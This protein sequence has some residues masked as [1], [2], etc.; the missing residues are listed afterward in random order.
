R[1][2]SM[3]QNHGPWNMLRP[4]PVLPAGASASPAVLAKKTGPTAPGRRESSGS[5]DAVRIARLLAPYCA[6]L[7][8]DEIEN[9]SPDITLL[10]PCRLHPPSTASTTRPADFRNVL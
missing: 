3:S 7:A 1:A 8:P 10:K 6:V 9:G 4:I 5:E 2:P